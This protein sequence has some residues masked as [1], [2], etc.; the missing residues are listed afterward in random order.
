MKH[1]HLAVLLAGLLLSLSLPAEA[2]VGQGLA[3]DFR[4]GLWHPLLGIDHI[5]VMVGVGLWAGFLGGAARGWLP[6]AF[7]AAM[8]AGGSLAFAGMVL[9]GPEIWVAASVLAIGAIL[10][11]VPSKLFFLAKN[12]GW[13]TT[14]IG[15]IFICRLSFP[16]V[17]THHGGCKRWV[18]RAENSVGFEGRRQSAPN[19]PY[20]SA[21]HGWASVLA[22]LFAFSHGYVHALE[23]GMGS[24]ALG[25][26]GGFL[27]STALLLGIGLM[28]GRVSARHGRWMRTLFG[29]ICA[30]AGIT[31]LLGI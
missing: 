30:G 16:R 24:Q 29:V 8:A 28:I 27:V 6:A 18:R 5:L 10:L 25:Y 4:A 20:V 13:V 9:Q 1:H 26:T 17:V 15:T 21:R 3:H 12:V 31:L 22:A 7:L 11:R 2:H 14:R 19:P 23:A